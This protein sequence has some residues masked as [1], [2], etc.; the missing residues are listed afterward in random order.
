MLQR[1]RW[2]PNTIRPLIAQLK[3]V[4]RLRLSTEIRLLLG[5]GKVCINCLPDRIAWTHHF[6]PGAYTD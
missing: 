3:Q 1:L 6:I 2:N 5:Q 4:Q